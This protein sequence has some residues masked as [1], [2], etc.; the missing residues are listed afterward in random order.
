MLRMTKLTINHQL[1]SFYILNDKTKFELTIIQAKDMRQREID[2]AV[3]IYFDWTI[4][5][6]ELEYLRDNYDKVMGS[7]IEDKTA[8]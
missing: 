6:T 4:P 3:R 5:T 2:D 8:I 1:F 7:I